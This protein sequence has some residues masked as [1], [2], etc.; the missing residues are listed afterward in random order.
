M[1]QASKNYGD[2]VITSSYVARTAPSG[3]H[4]I[5]TYPSYVA[6]GSYSCSFADLGIPAGSTIDSASITFTPGDPLHGDGGKKLTISGNL[7]TSVNSGMAIAYNQG[8]FYLEFKSGTS[9]TTYPAPDPDNYTYKT[10]SSA[11]R[12]G[13]FTLIVNYTLPYSACTAPSTVSLNANNVAPGAA[14]T[15]SWSVAAGGTNNAI[16][17]YKIQR[18]ASGAWSDLTTVTTAAT[19]GSLTVYAPTSNG[20]AYSYRII[21]MG[22]AGSSYYSAASGS[23]ALTCSFSAPSAPPTITLAGVA[24]N[25]YALAGSGNVTLAWSGAKAGTNNAITGYQVLRNGVAYGS[26]TTGSSMSVPI[27]AAGSSYIYSVITLGTYSNSGASTART[28]YS[29][30]HPT[31]PSTVTLNST[32][33]NIYVL[34]GNVTLAWGGA[35]EGSYNTITGY[36]VYQND[37]LYSSPLASP[38]TVPAGYT[39]KIVTKGER[40]NSAASVARV[41]YIYTPVGAP[42]SIIIAEDL[43]LPSTNVS[44]SWAGASAGTNNSITSYDVYRA[45]SLT[46]TYTFLQN[47]A[48]SPVSVSAPATS[49][50]S[51]FYKVLTRGQRDNSALSS[52]VDS[53]QAG[54]PPMQPV[55]VFPT[56]TIITHSNSP[57]I[58]VTVGAE[59]GGLTQE[60]QISINSG[61][62]TSLGAI[63]TAGETKTYVLSLTDATHTIA[64]RAKNSLGAYSAVTNKGVQVVPPVWNR[65]LASGTIFANTNISA[66]TDITNL[67]DIINVIRAYYNLTPISLTGVGQWAQWKSNLEALQTA[68]GQCF[69]AG[70]K[71]LPAWA[72][73]PAYPTAAIINTLR[74]EVRNA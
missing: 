23:V 6:S 1:P 26:A 25:P 15:L 5:S 74:S 34:A 70:E 32:G 73:V 64:L 18:Y 16:T 66:R 28:I 4:A 9:N 31:A 46:G 49:G 56:S 11:Y 24:G 14:V 13:S 40:S 62:Y 58:K 60:L 63:A 68:L 43:V 71:T 3:A 2:I 67:R 17:G 55:L 57:A 33:S 59:P 45:T 48:A 20:T 36:E 21:T 35:V 54:N 22:A 8:S 29:Y 61:A 38:L 37:V 19:S 7:Y 72:T 47:V 52:V 39:Y 53:I 41:A 27:A 30:S 50:Q 42:T 69:T 10:N 44:L 51:Y 12:F 65:A